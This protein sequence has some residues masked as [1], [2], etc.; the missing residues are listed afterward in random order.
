MT[1][2][3]TQER[4]ASTRFDAQLAYEAARLYFLEG[5]TQAEIAD[6]LGVSRP[7]VSRLVAEAR[8]IGLVHIEVRHPDELRSERGGDLA[9][10]LRTA[11][12]V[13]QVH[14]A[15]GDQEGREGPGLREATST[16]LAQ[17][18]LRPG[19]TMLLSSGRT[20][21]ALSQARLDIPPGVELIPTVGGVTEPEAWHQ[22]NEI[23]RH[24]AEQSYGRARFL[25]APAMPSPAMAR[26][27]AEDPDVRAI[28]SRWEDARTALVGIG[29]PTSTRSSI[30]R[31]VPALADE[32]RSAVGDVCLNFFDIDGTPVEFDGSDRMMCISTEQLR[33]LPS[34]VA[35]AVGAA[36]VTSIVGGA[37]AGL[38]T[39]LVTDT[40]TATALRDHLRRQPRP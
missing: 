8:R 25:F 31:A 13:Q 11:L 40:V 7:T 5:G 16:A 35:V 33:A 18:G 36:K 37:R 9:E 38:Y 27:L 6:R 4:G 22:T 15:P 23:V 21:Y 14:L 28:T 19:D 29:A 26:S 30:S 32:M 12:G 2:G 17:T 10:E 39:H 1:A 20:A 24:L 3:P 34:V